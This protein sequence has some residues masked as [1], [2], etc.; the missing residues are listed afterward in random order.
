M[1]EPTAQVQ[2]AGNNSTA[3]FDGPNTDR[4]LELVIDNEVAVHSWEYNE[5]QFEIWFYSTEYKTVTIAAAPGATSDQGTISFRSVVVDDGS[6][7]KATISAD[8]PVTLWTEDSTA[9]GQAYYLKPKNNIISGPYT[10]T[11]VRNAAIGGAL[12]VIVAV[13]YEAVAAKI[14]ATNRGERVA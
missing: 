4:K 14:G 10:G 6:L 1:A 11:D 7:S 8:G 13:L 9:E 12:A 2:T 5:G 3:T